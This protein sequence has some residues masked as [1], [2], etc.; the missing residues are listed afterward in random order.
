M[1]KRALDCFYGET[2]ACL[3]IF[4]NGIKFTTPSNWQKPQ[5]KRLGHVLFCFADI[6]TRAPKRMHDSIFYSSTPFCSGLCV[7][8]SVFRELR[9]FVYS[10]HLYVVAILI[11]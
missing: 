4:V 1:L 3:S 11:Y 6:F 2:F 8:V 7:C 9:F 10:E 5:W